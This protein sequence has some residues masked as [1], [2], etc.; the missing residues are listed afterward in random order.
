MKKQMTLEQAER[1]MVLGCVALQMELKEL[2]VDK[3][4]NMPLS[5]FEVLIEDIS[6]INKQAHQKA[7]LKE[8]R[9]K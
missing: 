6:Y 5:T 3:L 2:D 9:K 8:G 1:D 7:T 4:I